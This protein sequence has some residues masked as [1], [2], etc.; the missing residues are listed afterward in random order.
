VTRKWGHLIPT[1]YWS[2]EQIVQKHTRSKPAKPGQTR[3][4][5]DNNRVWTT[6]G[7]G[8]N[9]LL[10]GFGAGRCPENFEIWTNRQRGVK[11]NNCD[12]IGIFAPFSK[13][14]SSSLAAPTCPAILSGRSLGVGRSF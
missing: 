2:L 9:R 14:D 8:L 4:D 6:C 10:T 5:P 12:I 3:A 7:P 11:I 1:E 13:H